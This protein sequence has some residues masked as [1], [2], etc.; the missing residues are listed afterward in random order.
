MGDGGAQPAPVA[1]LPAIGP[2][3]DRE[4]QG[5]YPEIE[6]PKLALS[7]VHINGTDAGLFHIGSTVSN[8][9]E[10]ECR[11]YDA[12]GVTKMD[13]TAW[14][15]DTTEPPLSKTVVVN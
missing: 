10:F 5:Q 2:L 1:T 12:A 3:S 9:L 7:H 11:L 14:P 13:M 15:E 4:S 6:D 8:C